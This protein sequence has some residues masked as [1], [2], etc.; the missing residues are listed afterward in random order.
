MKNDLSELRVGDWLATVQ[1]GWLQIKNIH[2]NNNIHPIQTNHEYFT[3]DGKTHNYDKYP[4]A[5]ANPPQWLIDIIGPKPCDFKKGDKVLVKSM[6][7]GRGFLRRYFSHEKDDFYYCFN[8]GADEW[9]ADGDI[10]QWPKH[11][12]T[13]W[14]E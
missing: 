12:V 7:E 13:T 4:T 14:E 5:F 9:A 10:I 11:H 8:N 1:Y 2:Y 3:F 6:L